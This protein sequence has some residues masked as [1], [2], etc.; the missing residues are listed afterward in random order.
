MAIGYIDNDHLIDPD[1]PNPNRLKEQ[2]LAREYFASHDVIESAE[3][4]GMSW[5][6]HGGEKDKGLKGQMFGE[7]SASSGDLA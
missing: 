4:K 5:S 2:L 6:R 3:Y 1:N 7:L